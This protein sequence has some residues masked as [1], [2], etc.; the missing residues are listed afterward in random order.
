MNAEIKNVLALIEGDPQKGYQLAAAEIRQYI[1]ALEKAANRIIEDADDTIHM[2]RIERPGDGRVTWKS[3]NEL[4]RA[5][6]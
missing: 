2:R 1:E 3:L 5:M 6:K 4:S